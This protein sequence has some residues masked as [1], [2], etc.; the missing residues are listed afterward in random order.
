[1]SRLRPLTRT[2]G[3]MAG[4]V[5]S[6]V[7]LSSCVKV[8][9]LRYCCILVRSVGTL[10]WHILSS[11][12]FFLV[13]FHSSEAHCLLVTNELQLKINDRGFESE[14]YDTK[15][16]EDDNWPECGFPC[17]L[18]R[19]NPPLEFACFWKKYMTLS[20][21]SVARVSFLWTREHHAEQTRWSSLDLKHFFHACDRIVLNFYWL[22]SDTSFKG[23]L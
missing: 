3:T 13:C 10:Q 18:Y 5:L 1:M 11:F 15:E 12:L 21:E 19:C 20:L 6:N 22:K 9:V 2:A 8:H 17:V 4:L 7:L 14:F 16:R 23:E